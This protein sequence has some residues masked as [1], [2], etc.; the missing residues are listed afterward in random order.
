[1]KRGRALKVVMV[2]VGVLYTAAIYPIVMAL[3][4]PNP[5]DDTVTASDDRRIGTPQFRSS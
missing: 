2:L 1:M 3:R 4:H 5:S